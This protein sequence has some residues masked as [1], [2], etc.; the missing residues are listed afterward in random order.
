VCD[1]AEGWV[2]AAGWVT[3]QGHRSFFVKE[4]D[5]FKHV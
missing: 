1:P 3:E 4:E 5:D 2:A